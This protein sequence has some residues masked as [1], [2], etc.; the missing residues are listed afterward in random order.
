MKTIPLQAVRSQKF[1][2]P[3]SGQYA[4]ISVYQKSTGLYLD[5]ALADKTIVTGVICRDRVKIVRDAYMGFVGD[6]AFIDTQGTSDPDYTGLGTRYVLA[7]LEV[8]D[9]G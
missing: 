7:Y 3:L 8:A 9:L 5:L 6:L 1:T 4:T 2:V